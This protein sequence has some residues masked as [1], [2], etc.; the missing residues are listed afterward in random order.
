[1]RVV[2]GIIESRK[3]CDACQGA[4]GG[5]SKPRLSQ[6][7]GTAILKEE[8][9]RRPCGASH[10]KTSRRRAGGRGAADPRGM[11]KG[12]GRVRKVSEQVGKPRGLGLQII[13]DADRHVI[14]TWVAYLTRDRESLRPVIPTVR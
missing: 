9:L 3:P 10:L 1:M 14:T 4:S 5:S 6:A 7:R 13:G 2:A 11:S 12:Q 8:I